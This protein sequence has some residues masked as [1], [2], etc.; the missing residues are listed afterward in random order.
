MTSADW[1]MCRNRQLKTIAA[2]RL[3]LRIL[4][5]LGVKFITEVEQD[6]LCLF[7]IDAYQRLVYPVGEVDDGACSICR[8]G[9]RTLYR[10][11]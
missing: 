10:R 1:Y 5:D 7:S 9:I 2:I 4:L 8:D 11:V 3:D 6:S